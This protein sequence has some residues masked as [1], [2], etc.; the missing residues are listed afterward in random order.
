MMEPNKAINL[1]TS[2]SCLYVAPVLEELLGHST[3]LVCQGVNSNS[4]CATFFFGKNSGDTI[5]YFLVKA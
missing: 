3:K 1:A 4:K 2:K 5:I